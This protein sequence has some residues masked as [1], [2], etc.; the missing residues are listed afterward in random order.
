VLA[1][2]ETTACPALLVS[3]KEATLKLVAM[4]LEPPEPARGTMPEECAK[5]RCVFWG[6]DTPLGPMVVAQVTAS[7]SD[8]AAGAHLGVVHE[9]TLL[10]IDL[11]AG[12]GEPVF[13]DHGDLGPAFCLEPWACKQSLGLFVVPR[14]AAARGTDPPEELSAREGVYALTGDFERTDSTSRE[15][16]TKIAL[17]LP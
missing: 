2:I 7:E 16:C 6:K 17:E 3:E 1:R 4:D 5:G 14:L 13:G 10:F 11:W 8:M 15:G 9:E 12:A